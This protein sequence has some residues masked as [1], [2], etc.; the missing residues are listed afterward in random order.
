MVG[1]R[2]EVSRSNAA[3]T[4][5]AVDGRGRGCSEEGVPASFTGGM[6]WEGNWNAGAAEEAENIQAD[7]SCCARRPHSSSFQSVWKVF[8]FFFNQCGSQE[9]FVQVV[10]RGKKKKKKK[11][12]LH[13]RQG[14]IVCASTTLT[15]GPAGD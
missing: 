15:A 1:A 5:Q 3:G 11:K 7:E 8:W 4:H 9:P 10:W 6:S 14:E 2:E 13:R 12:N